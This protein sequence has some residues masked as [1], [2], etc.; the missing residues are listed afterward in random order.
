LSFSLSLA[1]N[2]NKREH[3]KDVG[4]I[5]RSLNIGDGHKGAAGGTVYCTSKAEMLRKKGEIIN[6]IFGLWEGQN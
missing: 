1:L 5:M 6:E 3:R 4:E 2:L